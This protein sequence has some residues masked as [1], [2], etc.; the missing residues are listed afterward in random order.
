MRIRLKNQ[1]QRRQRCFVLICWQRAQK[2]FSHN[3]GLDFSDFTKNMSISHFSRQ[4]WQVIFEVFTSSLIF[5]KMM[6]L[7]VVSHRKK[8][9]LK[10]IDFY[11]RQILSLVQRIVFNRRNYSY[12]CLK[13]SMADRMSTPLG[14]ILSIMAW[15][16]SDSPKTFMLSRT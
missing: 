11:Y 9:I 7:L 2:A 13:L 1:V 15:T 4:N 10:E 16:G 5:K 3:T 8:Y 6:I 12:F 14:I